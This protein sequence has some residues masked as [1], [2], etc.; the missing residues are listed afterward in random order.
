MVAVAVV[1]AVVVC[2]T[3]ATV[4]F[5]GVDN[6]FAGVDNTFVVVSAG[7]A[8]LVALV[9]TDMVLE[10]LVPSCKKVVEE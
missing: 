2:N 4:S 10:V 1:A 8:G 5:A 3:E 6:T 7:L 9:V